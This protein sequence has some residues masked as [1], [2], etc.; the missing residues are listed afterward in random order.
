MTT[1]EKIGTIFLFLMFLFAIHLT[2]RLSG[3][4]ESLGI[5]AIGLIFIDLLVVAVGILLATFKLTNNKSLLLFVVLIFISFFT[6]LTYHQSYNSH[7]ETRSVFW[8]YNGEKDT[9]Y[10]DH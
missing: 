4:K 2:I 5:L 7:R 6:F 1:K 9:I 8:G 3:H 10:N